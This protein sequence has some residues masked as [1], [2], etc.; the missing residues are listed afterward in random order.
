MK[1]KKRSPQARSSLARGS[2]R[3]SFMGRTRDLEN[4]RRITEL[5]ITER[6]EG[7]EIILLRSVGHATPEIRDLV[8]RI[9]AYL[10]NPDL[11]RAD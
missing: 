2:G 8:K 4:G 1:H 9:V 11:Q 5:E 10:N 3:F 7:E 6:I